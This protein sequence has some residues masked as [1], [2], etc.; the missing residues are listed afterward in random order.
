MILAWPD[1][2]VSGSQQ[3]R[4]LQ[5][6]GLGVSLFALQGP[7]AA[8]PSLL[9]LSPATTFQSMLPSSFCFCVKAVQ[10]LKGTLQTGWGGEWLWALA[11][12]R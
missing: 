5:V 8:A 10:A 12:I 9:S 6:P 1:M 11:T 3:K 4:P 2:F 7:K